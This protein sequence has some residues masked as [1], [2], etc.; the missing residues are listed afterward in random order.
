MKSPTRKKARI[1]LRI[2]PGG[3]LRIPLCFLYRS[4]WHSGDRL[5]VEVA[6]DRIYLVKPPTEIVWRI[7]RLRQRIGFGSADDSSISAVR[8]YG[9]Y[10]RMTL[11]RCGPFPSRGRK[12][13]NPTKAIEAISTV[14]SHIT[15]AGGNIFL[16]LGFPPE[17][18]ERLKEESDRRR[19]G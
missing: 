15:P 1:T 5:I 16:D 10:R 7:E 2:K 4:G 11:P 12:T 8:T 14:I 13:D 9:E 19:G 18:A 3:F 17:E 6:G